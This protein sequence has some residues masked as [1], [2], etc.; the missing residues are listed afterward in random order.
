MSPPLVLLYLGVEAFKSTNFKILYGA[1]TANSET[2]IPCGDGL[3]FIGLYSGGVLIWPT[4]WSTNI[5]VVAGAYP[6]SVTA[7]K[8]S[9]SRVVKVNNQGATEYKWVYLGFT[10]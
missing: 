10:A 4:Y 7:T 1:V 8:T 3:L 9:S 5:E 6:G 2:S